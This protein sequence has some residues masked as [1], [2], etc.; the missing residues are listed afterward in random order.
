MSAVLATG[1]PVGTEG[2]VAISHLERQLGFLARIA[3][4]LVKATILRKAPGYTLKYF[5]DRSHVEKTMVWCQ[6]VQQAA[7]AVDHLARTG[8]DNLKNVAIIISRGLACLGRLTDTPASPLLQGDGNMI[9][10]GMRQ[11]K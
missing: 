6:V 2:V 8:M 7:M 4:D 1:D 9:S 5:C 10:R 3:V 11:R